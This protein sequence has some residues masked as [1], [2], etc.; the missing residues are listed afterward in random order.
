M[1]FYLP[2][3][4][5]GMYSHVLFYRSR[6]ANLA[7]RGIDPNDM[8]AQ[9][10]ACE[11]RGKVLLKEYME[12]QGE[13]RVVS[14]DEHEDILEPLKGAFQLMENAINMAG[15]NLLLEEIPL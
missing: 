3:Y 11:E 15:K 10:K 12:Q 13:N 14:K 1:G 7:A 2:I 9:I 6:D 4:H 8:G 5:C